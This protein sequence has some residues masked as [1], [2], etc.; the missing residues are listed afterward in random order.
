MD[1]RCPTALR[2]GVVVLDR[3]IAYTLGSLALVTPAALDRP[4]PC[5]RWDLRALLEHLH[6]S[7]GALQ[8]AAEI[9]SVA[10][11]PGPPCGREVISMVRHRAVRMLGAWVQMRGLLAVRVAGEPMT[12]PMVAGAGAI[13]VA[14]HGWDMARACGHRRPVPDDLADELLDLAR[15]LVSGG[16]RP[17]RFASPVGL[18][19]NAP[20]G[21]RLVAFLGRDPR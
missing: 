12:A 8:E 15:V 16:D 13:E 5:A 7:M 10:D 21:D 11:D 19:P 3:A 9:G 17:G 14:V 4:T 2:G 1:D 18:A 6:D 20:A